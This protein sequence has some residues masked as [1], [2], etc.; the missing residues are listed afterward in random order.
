MRD[1]GGEG[2]TRKKSGETRK[3]KVDSR[4]RSTLLSVPWGSVGFRG[5]PLCPP[6]I[7]LSPR[8]PIC[9]PSDKWKA[10][11]NHRNVRY[12]QREEDGGKREEEKRRSA[13]E[14]AYLRASSTLLSVPSGSAGFRG[15]P[16]RPSIHYPVSS[17]PYAALP[18]NG[19][20]PET[21][22]T[23]GSAGGGEAKKRET[24]KKGGF[25]GAIEPFGR[26]L[27]FRRIPWVP[28]LSVVPVL[29]LSSLLDPICR[30]SYK[31]KAFR[32]H[33]N[34]LYREM[35]EATRKMEEEKRRNA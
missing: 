21:A 8:S 1:G 32:N 13:L 18:T 3:K 25:E 33:R 35:D 14:K 34:V 19:K 4:E 23:L 6:H 20:R 10:F 2:E 27:G 5:C 11:R 31:W 16:L 30:P 15:C 7:I 9:R 28:R 12:W 24:R 17:P 29:P 26:S 22:E